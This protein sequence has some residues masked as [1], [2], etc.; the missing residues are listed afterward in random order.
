MLLKMQYYFKK[1]RYWPGA[2]DLD[3]HL[4]AY[5]K[6]LDLKFVSN[7]LTNILAIKSLVREYAFKEQLL[8]ERMSTR[9]TPISPVQVILNQIPAFCGS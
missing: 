6:A 5:Y 2:S 4:P 8:R 9:Q 7:Q 1:F 3:R